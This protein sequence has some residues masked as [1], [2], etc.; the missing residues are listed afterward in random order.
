[1]ASSS[2]LY[3]TAPYGVGSGPPPTTFS[4][5]D[6][7][8]WTAAASYPPEMLNIAKVD[9]TGKL[10]F[11]IGDSMT[12]QQTK[13]IYESA[14]GSNWIRGIDVN[15]GFARDAVGDTSIV[16]VAGGGVILRAPKP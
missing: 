14:E 4:S 8:T 10:W 7:V 16:L 5:P 3:V 6:G 9:Y 1:V 13:L 2:T 12:S 15:T 11:A